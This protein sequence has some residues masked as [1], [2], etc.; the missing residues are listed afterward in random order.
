MFDNSSI[1]ITGGTGSFGNAF[2]SMTLKKYNPKKIVIFSRDEMKQWEMAKLFPNDKRVRF[3]CDLRK[4]SLSLRKYLD[5][6][7][8][9]KIDEIEK[10]LSQVKDK[11]FIVD[12]NT[13]SV[14]FEEII[15]KKNKISNFEDPVYGL[16]AIKNKREIENIKKVHIYDGIA[17]TKFLFWIKKNVKKTKITEISA[18]KRL[19]QLKKKK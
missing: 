8:I 18:A 9:K 16:K 11:K 15:L 17:L 1:L 7:Q 2:V 10:I 13:C 5:K 3:F 4:L 12:R 19:Y 14:Y 6:I